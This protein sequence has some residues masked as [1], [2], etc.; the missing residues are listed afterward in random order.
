MDKDIVNW[1]KEKR[2]GERVGE[3]EKEWWTYRDGRFDMHVKK[4]KIYSYKIFP[5]NFVMRHGWSIGWKLM[6]APWLWINYHQSINTRR[7]FW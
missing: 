7:S 4:I 5:R 2:T 3:R 1:M 6:R